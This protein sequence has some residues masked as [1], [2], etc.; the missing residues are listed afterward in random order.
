MWDPRSGRP[1][2]PADAEAPEPYVE[3]DEEATYPESLPEDGDPA[4]PGDEA[5]W[6]DLPYLDTGPDREPGTPVGR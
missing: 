3:P 1:T 2:P 4:R 5:G 6:P